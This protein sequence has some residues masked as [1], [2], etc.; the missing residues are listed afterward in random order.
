MVQ[1]LQ[2]RDQSS[3]AGAH[4][5]ADPA[6]SLFGERYSIDKEIGRGGMGRVF[7]AV[8]LRL[9]RR[10]AVKILAPGVHGDEQLRRFQ[11][12]AR[13]AASLQQPNILDVFD[14]GVDGGEPYIVSELLEGATL[15]ERLA[16]GP[17]P[18]LDALGYA[19]QL[20]AGLAAAHANGVV[21]RDLKPE[22]L[23]IT[24]DD[25]L[26]ILDFGVAK[27]LPS[28]TPGSGPAGSSTASGGIV[29]TTPYMSPEQIRGASVD[30]RSDVFSF[31]AIVHEMLTGT[32]AFRGGSTVET[33]YSVL[34]S[35]P[36]GLPRTVPQELSRIVSRCLEKDPADR[37][38][39]A[40]ALAKD[41]E[42]AS[43]AAPAGRAWRT[44]R[45]IPW[46][47]AC[48]ALAAFLMLYWPRPRTS[49]AS[50]RQLA[51][52]PF[53][54]VGGGAPQDAFATGLSELLTNKLRQIEQFPGNLTV[55]SASEVL[56]EN[57][58]S[59][60]AA[61]EAFGATIVLNGSVHWSDTTALVSLE[62]VETRNQLLLAARDVEVPKDQ[63][64]SLQ[65]A[66]VQK[67]AGMLD[68]HLQP[69]AR[70]ALG[71]D[72]TSAASALEFYLQGRGY[73][74]RYDRVEN[75]ES[76]IRVFD[77]A[78]AIDESYALAHAGKAEALLRLFQI[79]RDPDVV[80]RA[81]ASASRAVELGADLAPVR[82]TMGLVQL[83][84][85]RT[86]EAIASFRR[87]L[88]SEPRNADALRELARAYE[89][90]GQL[91]EA[92]ATFRQAIELR[93]N[94]WATYK[95]LAVFLNQRGRLAEAVP[96]LERVANLTPD[97]YSAYS[98]LG[99]IYLRL[100][101]FEDAERSLRKS[102]ELRPTGIAYSNLGSVAYLQGRYPD[103]TE[104]YR[105]ATELNPSDDRLWGALADSYRWTPGREAEAAPAFRRA[106]SVS[107]Q[108]ISLDPNN[109]QLHSRRAQ[110]WS[111]LGDKERAQQELAVA[112][113]S[114][115]GNGQVLFRA[116]IVHE[117][118]GRR[119]EALR[120]LKEAIAAGHSMNEIVNAP[121]L[122]ALR[123]DPEVA[124][125]I[126]E[127]TAKPAR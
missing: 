52:L 111:A 104:Q 97:S 67:A 76:A 125:L 98:N 13:A 96:Y 50:D 99:G 103:A 72:A 116:A 35:V 15:R 42:Q 20:A 53:D 89:A 83:A 30:P 4:A 46:A 113:K 73:L 122:R 6:P 18:A 51:V 43:V 126:A 25:R 81:G 2:G 79:S 40:A 62:L 27:L 112:L 84:R 57:V 114:A 59:A 66:L 69:A 70:R 26:K 41:L 100:G 65:I 105:K 23:F 21:H 68:F 64:A 45:A 75:L 74:Q 47:I 123:Q 88:A 22:N 54:S 77:Q 119:H 121:P 93:Q 71:V 127:R 14:V 38:E 3:G 39:D 8:D 12:E 48:A 37:Y 95:E 110:Y 94:S 5:T 61:R 11:V 9:G 34:T 28:D 90:A 19:R 82:V 24:R 60:R 92:E 33:G 63:L 16:R 87:A 78:I 106:L 108:Q 118:A 44:P 117:Q 56:R 36:A 86:T 1:T 58:R 7:S 107:D 31:G 115:P 124:R 32:P 91:A 49:L 120:E 85:G 55:V 101:R 17:L 102:L 80:A 29:G 10:V 109:A